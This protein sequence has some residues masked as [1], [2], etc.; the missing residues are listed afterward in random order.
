MRLFGRVHIAI[1]LPSIFPT[2]FLRGPSPSRSRPDFLINLLQDWMRLSLRGITPRRLPHPA[3]C[4][5]LLL[6]HLPRQ[7]APQRSVVVAV[8]PVMLAGPFPAMRSLPVLP[9]VVA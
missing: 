6:R 8:M 4:A 5:C 1:R 9:A 3:P 2:P 7:I